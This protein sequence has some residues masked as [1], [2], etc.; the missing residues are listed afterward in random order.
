MRD[1]EQGY[2][3]EIQAL[4]E[5][6][7]ML[8]EELRSLREL[9]NLDDLTGLHNIRYLGKRLEEEIRGFQEKGREFSLV[10][11]DIDNLKAVNDSLGHLAG[12]S[13]I[14][15]VARCL[16]TTLRAYDVCVRYGGDEF[17][18]LLP[19]TEEDKAAGVAWRI[20]H[21]IAGQAFVYDRHPL[22]ITV[23]AGVAGISRCP[24]GAGEVF[25][26]ADEFLYQSKRQGRN[27]VSAGM[28]PALHARVGGN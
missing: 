1:R 21:S 22:S 12:S 5:R 28:T 4:R 24:G 25:R 19:E 26:K 9:V 2:L 23:S 20:V 11:I 7:G 17:V 18:I 16:K 6:T 13:V 27:R 15:A 8:E 3:E 10:M 14:R